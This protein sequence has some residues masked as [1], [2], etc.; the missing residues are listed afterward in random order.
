MYIFSKECIYALQTYNILLYCL[1][2]V[3]NIG[4]VYLFAKDAQ[5][6][7]LVETESVLG[8]KFFLT[9]FF[10]FNVVIAMLTVFS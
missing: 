9:R 4:I 8:F 2:W 5:L 10:V 7:K 6:K 1:K 3:V